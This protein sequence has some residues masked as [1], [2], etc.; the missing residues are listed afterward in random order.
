MCVEHESLCS[1]VRLEVRWTHSVYLL[2]LLFLLAFSLP[3]MW[4]GH[5]ETLSNLRE[6]FNVWWLLGLGRYQTWCRST[7]N[8][9]CPWIPFH[10]AYFS[11]IK[12][13]QWLSI[14]WVTLCCEGMTSATSALETE[15]SFRKKESSK[16]WLR[17][18][19]ERGAVSCCWRYRYG[20]DFIFVYYESIKRELQTRPIYECQCES[21]PC[22]ERLK[23]KAE[24]S[25]YLTYTGLLGE[26]EHLKIETR[27]IDEMFTR[28]F[29]CLLL[30]D[31]ARTKD[32]TYIWFSVRW[33]TKT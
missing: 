10:C 18:G 12:G 1:R 28:K 13:W 24:E 4:S 8:S 27:S 15:L 6:F 22:D 20:L 3:F 26:L 2:F 17:W 7:R 9:T 14:C 29:S 16:R 30:I 25:T 19:S 5:S 21:P 32:K 33:K 31:K 23:P 11:W